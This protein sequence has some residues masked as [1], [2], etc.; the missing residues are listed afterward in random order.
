MQGHPHTTDSH[1]WA[2]PLPHPGQL[3]E[4]AEKAALVLVQYRGPEGPDVGTGADQQDDHGQQALE[5][6]KSRHFL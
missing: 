6:K 4:G 3:P 5:V 2:H 1:P